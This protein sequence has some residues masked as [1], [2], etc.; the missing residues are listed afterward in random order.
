MPNAPYSNRWRLLKTELK[1]KINNKRGI[2][3]VIL[4]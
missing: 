1:L 2:I 3:F 4:Q